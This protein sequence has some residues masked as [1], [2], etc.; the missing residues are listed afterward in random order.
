MTPSPLYTVQYTI[1]LILLQVM[2]IVMI[3]ENHN[4]M[5]GA[6]EQVANISSFMNL[7]FAYLS[8]Y[9][10]LNWSS[11]NCQMEVHGTGMISITNLP[12]MFSYIDKCNNS[13]NIY[14][15]FTSPEGWSLVG[16][17]MNVY[18]DECTSNVYSYQD[19]KPAIPFS[20]LNIC[21]AVVMLS[22]MI[23]LERLMVKITPAP[24]DPTSRDCAPVDPIIVI[25]M[26]TGVICGLMIVIYVV[27]SYYLV[28]TYLDITGKFHDSF[29]GAQNY[30]CYVMALNCINIY[31]LGIHGMV[32]INSYD[33][34]KE[35]DDA[36][37]SQTYDT[38]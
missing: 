17:I 35:F 18:H 31:I 7:K 23:A 14:E 21:L 12:Q 8:E 28:A 29:Y 9:Q 37:T 24:L 20:I 33:K 13:N 15:N 5:L 25:I 32:I 10:G 22:L 11:N 26:I 2:S 1:I 19:V 34:W 38:I 27:N 4:R 6:S 16:H 36:Q 30:L 3:Y